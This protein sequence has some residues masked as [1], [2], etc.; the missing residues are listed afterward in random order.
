MNTLHT[1][2]QHHRALLPGIARRAM[3]ERGLLPDFSPAA[4][5]ELDKL[6]APARVTSGAAFAVLP[7]TFPP[8]RDSGSE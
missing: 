6:Q 4:L 5:A 1:N 3:F 2:D 8:S 7:V